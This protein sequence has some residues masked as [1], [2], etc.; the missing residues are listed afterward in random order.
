MNPAG[1]DSEASGIGPVVRPDIDRSARRID[2]MI[3]QVPFRLLLVSA[4]VPQQQPQPIAQPEIEPWSAEETA[5]CLAGEQQGGHGGLTCG[6]AG[7]G[8]SIH[9][10]LADQGST[11]MGE[12]LPRE[13]MAADEM[14]EPH[15][16]QVGPRPDGGVGGVGQHHGIG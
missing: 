6:R 11:G 9:Q 12:A 13:A 1:Q 7:S 4:P 14:A 16:S 5:Q 15:L 8:G 3:E 2:Q 10:H